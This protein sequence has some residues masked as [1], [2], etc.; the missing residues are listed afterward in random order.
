MKPKWQSFPASVRPV[1]N[2]S[3]RPFHKN[4]LT[5]RQIFYNQPT[6]DQCDPAFMPLDNTDNPR[7]DWY[8]LWPILGYFR[9]NPPQDGQWYGFL[10]PKF[11]QKTGLSGEQFQAL[12]S[13]LEGRP[14]DSISVLKDWDQTT[15]FQNVFFQGEHHHRGL[16]AVSQ[17]FLGAV[18]WPLNLHD[19]MGHSANTVFSNYLVASARFWRLWLYL[20]E[21][22]VAMV[23]DAQHPL[24][25][26]LR[27]KTKYGK[28]QAARFVFIQERLPNIILALPGWYNHPIVN[29]EATSRIFPN[30]PDTRAVQ[31][32]CDDIKKKADGINTAQIKEAFLQ[33]R[34]RLQPLPHFFAM[35]DK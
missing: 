19:H 23:E 27:A 1:L 31:A 28:A 15:Y 25:A 7:P 20:A 6:R 29:R 14:A 13:G 11:Q 30:D 4:K 2:A 10:S 33:Q 5:I 21:S 24:S 35:H 16:L 12:L 17:A 34:N 8:E 3:A 26:V 22:L 32:A 9:S 18:Q